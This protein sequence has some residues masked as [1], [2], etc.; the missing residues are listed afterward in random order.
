MGARSNKYHSDFSLQ[1][2]LMLFWSFQ[3]R[4][5]LL[6]NTV[7]C[8]SHLVSYRKPLRT[9]PCASLASRKPPRI[10]RIFEKTKH[11]EPSKPQLSRPRPKVSTTLTIL[12]MSCLETDNILLQPRD[13]QLVLILHAREPLFQVADITPHLR[14]V[15]ADDVAHAGARA[16]TMAGVAARLRGRQVCLRREGMLLQQ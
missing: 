4:Y 11:I 2:G 12:V 6:F 7:Q 16:L 5:A 3:Q 13:P 8:N 1:T 15:L 10:S 9:F 14:W